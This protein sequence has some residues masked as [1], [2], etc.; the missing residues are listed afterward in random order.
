MSMNPI[1][2]T[3]HKAGEEVLCLLVDDGYKRRIVLDV[4]VAGK[5]DYLDFADC[6]CEFISVPP[7]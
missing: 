2:F 1:E 3:F 5:L 7:R 4:C 6:N